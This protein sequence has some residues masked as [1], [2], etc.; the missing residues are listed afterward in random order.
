[1]LSHC[2]AIGRVSLQEPPEVD[3]GSDGNEVGKKSMF[4]SLE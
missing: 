1:M 2:F 3:L 4:K